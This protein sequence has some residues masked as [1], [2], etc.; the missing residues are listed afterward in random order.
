MKKIISTTMLA[1]LLSFCLVGTSVALPLIGTNDND[2]TT[3]AT[4]YILNKY[5]V[6]DRSGGVYTGATWTGVYLG[7]IVDETFNENN[8]ENWAA[9]DSE[10]DLEA[11]ISY[12]LGYSYNI[13]TYLKAKKNNSWVDTEGLITLTVNFTVPATIPATGTWDVDP[14]IYG[15]DFYAVKGANDFA[16]YAVSPAQ[17]DGKW[18]TAHLLN[19]GG[20][21]PSLSHLSGSIVNTPVPEPATMLLFGTGLAGLAAVARRRKN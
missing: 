7:T 1:G 3:E 12:Y 6:V 4:D 20:N 2:G 10:T 5:L 9:N 16:L 11:L 17:S 13:V 8:P 14:D 15:L 19:D 18:T 21:V